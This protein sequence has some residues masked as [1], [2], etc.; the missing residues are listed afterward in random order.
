MTTRDRLIAAAF[1]GAGLVWTGLVVW[2]PTV[3]AFVRW[4]YGG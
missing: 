3:R 4:W 1:L 2:Q